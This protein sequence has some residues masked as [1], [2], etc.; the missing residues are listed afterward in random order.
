MSKSIPDRIWNYK[1]FNMV[2]ELDIAGEFIYDGIHIFNQINSVEQEAMLFSFLYHISVGIERVQKIVLVLFEEVTT[3]NYEEFEESLKTHSHYA[4][5]ERILQHTKL[6]LT[7]R[8]TMFLQLISEIYKTARYQRFNV[9]SQHKQEQSLISDFIKQFLPKEKLQY[10]FITGK[11]LVTDDVKEMFGRIIGSISRKYYNLI[12]EGARNNNTYTYELRAESKAQKVFSKHRNNS[13][14]EQKV[15][16]M[17]VL[18][19]FLVYL[20]NTKKTNSFLRFLE[21]IPPLDLDIALLNTYIDEI[22]HGIV[23][24]SLIDEV[25]CLYEENSYSIDRIN[26]V[27]LI[28]NTNVLFEYKDIEECLQMLKG[29]LTG[30]Y[31]CEYFAK[32]FPE[33]FELIDDEDIYEILKEV[34][35]LC[36]DFL[37]GDLSAHDF[38]QKIEVR[39]SEIENFFA[40]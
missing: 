24:Q 27:N 4:L 37:N 39:Y 2:V 11:V 5:N 28:G 38:K 19:E 12:L 26:H 35:S 20:R 15:D 9:I 17:T 6:Q 25:E 16:E 32:C 30:N 3:D 34:P 23:S 36:A 1:N 31:D 8:E 18:K 10:H 33:K 13:L 40:K 14:Q 29:L 21:D 22:C 7:S